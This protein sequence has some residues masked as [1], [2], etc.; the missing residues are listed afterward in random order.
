M[1]NKE[2]REDLKILKDFLVFVP[3][4]IKI[5]SKIVDENKNFDRIL[6]QSFYSEDIFFSLTIWSD[7]L[8]SKMIEKII[9][10]RLF[11]IK[12]IKIKNPE[13]VKQDNLL[14]TEGLYSFVIDLQN[15]HI[16]CQELERPVYNSPYEFSSESDIVA[17]KNFLKKFFDERISSQYLLY[18]NYL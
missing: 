18:K 17:Q 4:M 6:Y 15:G 3:D 9:K 8:K 13:K 2:K 12:E 1:P 11:D 5:I 14:F 10:N 7:D 16:I